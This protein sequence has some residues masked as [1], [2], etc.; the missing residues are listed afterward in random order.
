MPPGGARTSALT[1]VVN[2][3][4]FRASTAPEAAQR[5]ALDLL[6]SPAQG[7]RIVGLAL[8]QE[9]GGRQGFDEVLHLIAAS[10]TAFEM[11]HALLALQEQAPALDPTQV[12]RAISTLENEMAD[13]RSVGI[14]QDPGLSSLLQRT[15]TILR[16]VE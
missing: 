8:V 14:Q 16:G 11:F 12:E 10:S 7:D 6:R 1:R 9:T 5:K 3:A 13:P 4:S 15:V 2:E